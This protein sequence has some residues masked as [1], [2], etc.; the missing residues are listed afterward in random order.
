MQLDRTEIEIRQR[1]GLELFDLSVVVLRNH[2]WP[3]FLTSLVICLP[4]LI[5]DSIIIR[6]M[7]TE[8]ALFAVEHMDVP[9]SALLNRHAAHLIALFCVQFPLMSLPT[10]IML[11]SLVFYQPMSMR[12]L[13]TRLRPIAWRCLLVMGIMRF[14][15]VVLLL[16]LFVRM[17][18]PFDWATELL[19]LIVLPGWAILVRSFAPFAPEILGLELCPLRSKDKSVITYRGRSR[20]LHNTL[21]GEH[22]G[23]MLGAV[24]CGALLLAMLIGLQLTFSGV[25]TGVWHW[26]AIT[27]Y[28]GLPASLWCLGMF[29]SVVRFLSYLDSRIRLEGWEIE[30]RMRAEAD[31]LS[32]KQRI[33]TGSLS[34]GGIKDEDS[35]SASTLA[36]TSAL[37]NEVT[38][39][40]SKEQ[41]AS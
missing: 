39:S 26:T 31:R 35:N 22:M 32:G 40:G 19:I 30:L 34:D 28:V 15:L 18:V 20:R 36:D 10:T 14:G 16:E 33:E 11:G 8:R 6:W 41:V 4:L 25:A 37:S 7:L 12:E 27:S 23:R 29:F 3:I 24:F 13:L 1:S 21:A 17:E 2:I 5:V 38:A 9:E